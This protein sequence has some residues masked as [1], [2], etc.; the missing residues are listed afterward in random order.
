ML[1]SIKWQH[2]RD[3]F[4]MMDRAAYLPLGNYHICVAMPRSHP[5]ASKPLLEPTDLHGQRLIIIPSGVTAELDAIRH[6]L[7]T[8]HPPIIIETT[9]SFYDLNTFN[10]CEETGALLLTFDA[11]ASIHPSLITRPVNWSF[12]APTASYIRR[13]SPAKPP[14]SSASCK[15]P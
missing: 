10:H 6:W 7:E 12:T 2:I 1:E 13:Q 11:W 14:A 9:D 5:L 3:I 15:T 8:E 4:L